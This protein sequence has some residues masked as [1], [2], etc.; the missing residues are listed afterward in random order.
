MAIHKASQA[1]VAP[2]AG[3]ESVI[4]NPKHK[5]LDQIRK[6]MRL[7]HYSIRTERT[8]GE[9][10][11]RHVHF[12]RMQCREDLAGG[13]TFLSGLAV[14]GNVVPATQNQALYALVFR[15][16]RGLKVPLEEWINAVRADRK[17]NRCPW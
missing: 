12:H 16:K 10:I 15:Y 11:R 13:E 7:K 1:W 5:L 17:A 2:A 3:C 8:Y 14:D 6:V 4:P 9:W